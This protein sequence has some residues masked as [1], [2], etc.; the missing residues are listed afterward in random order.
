MRARPVAAPDPFASFARR[1]TNRAFPSEKPPLLLATPATEAHNATATTTRHRGRQ[2]PRLILCD[3]MIAPEP[4]V[5]QVSTLRDAASV[6][7]HP[8]AVGRSASGAEV[9]ICYPPRYPTAA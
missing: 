5:W 8:G 6:R 7:W 9:L 4:A 3:D 1:A 2:K